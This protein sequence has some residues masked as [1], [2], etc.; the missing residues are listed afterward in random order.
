MLKGWLGPDVGAAVVPTYT[1]RSLMARNAI[2]F[3]TSRVG[4]GA[5]IMP[6]VGHALT[7]EGAMPVAG[8][9]ARS[10]SLLMEALACSF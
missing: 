3:A 5:S 6:L 8:D 2:H 4:V 1:P 9:A 7:Q 10:G